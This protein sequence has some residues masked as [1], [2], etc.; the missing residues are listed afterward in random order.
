MEGEEEGAESNLPL[1]L[2]ICHTNCL[3][4]SIT[5]RPIKSKIKNLQAQNNIV[6]LI[7]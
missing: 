7:Y 6:I 1:S 5:N 4:F 3:N 2:N